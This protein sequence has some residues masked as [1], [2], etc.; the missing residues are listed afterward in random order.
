M[1]NLGIIGFG[2]L[3]NHI[4]E[5][6]LGR[7]KI[8]ATTTTPAKAQELNNKGYHA[9]LTSFPDTL[10]AEMQPWTVAKDLDAIIVF[11]N[12]G[13]TDSNESQTPEPPQFPWQL[14]RSIVFN[15]FDRRLSSD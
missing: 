13:R 11:R 2:W 5:R 6:L 3:G 8:F 12:P 1:Q 10:D 15:E 7:Y 9:T 14:Q 4:A